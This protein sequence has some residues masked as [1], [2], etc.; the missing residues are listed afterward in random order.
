MLTYTSFS[1][2]RAKNDWKLEE[3]GADEAINGFFSIK[4]L[5]YLVQTI[6]IYSRWDGG[7]E[8]ASNVD[9]RNGTLEGVMNS[10]MSWG[11]SNSITFWF[12]MN[13]NTLG[14]EGFTTYVSDLAENEFGN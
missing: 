14:W 3:I 8:Y 1:K 12:P 13:Q 5:E 11:H 6:F 7:M 10:Y 9:V 2:K 4:T